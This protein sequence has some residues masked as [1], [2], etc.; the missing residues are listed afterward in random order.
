M[1]LFIRK[2]R[3]DLKMAKLKVRDK[4]LESQLEKVVIKNKISAIQ[5]ELASYILQNNFTFQIV[6]DYAVLL[7]A[8]ERKFF[9]GES[10]LFLVNF[11]EQKYIDSKLKAIRLENN[12]FE[13]KA[14]LF[15]EAV[16][17]SN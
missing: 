7:A 1:P 15:R 16:L 9:L 12:F 13:A 2:E 8:E 3:G 11:R 10:S 17:S 14:R 6:R 5:Q 4:Q